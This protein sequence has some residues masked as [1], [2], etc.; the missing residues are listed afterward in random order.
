MGSYADYEYENVLDEADEADDAS[1]AIPR[2]RSSLGLS[3]LAYSSRPSQVS[4]G[5]SSRSSVGSGQRGAAGDDACVFMPPH[6]PLVGG[7]AAA[8]FEAAR[9]D[10]YLSRHAERVRER[11]EED[12]ID[13]YETGEPLQLR[14][15]DNMERQVVIEDP[16]V[17]DEDRSVGSNY[18]LNAPVQF[19]ESPRRDA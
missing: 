13:A 8:A 14:D 1:S 11:D 7:G 10:F 9:H 19:V 18:T 3:L 2:T 15:N 4:F 12:N 16:D 17:G 6:R 5:S